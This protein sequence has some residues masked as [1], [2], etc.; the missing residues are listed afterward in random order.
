MILFNVYLSNESSKHKLHVLVKNETDL[1]KKKS[2]KTGK[3][4]LAN[5]RPENKNWI[6]EAWCLYKALEQ[7]ILNQSVH[8]RQYV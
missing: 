6:I 5:W 3:S 4:G 8:S 7:C 2:D 1:A